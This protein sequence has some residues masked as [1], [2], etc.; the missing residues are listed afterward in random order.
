ML[1][2][3]VYFHICYGFNFVNFRTAECF[4]LLDLFTQ[5]VGSA[6]LW[7]FSYIKAMVEM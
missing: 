2:I 1:F 3:F 5:Q 4:V 6:Y 7:Y